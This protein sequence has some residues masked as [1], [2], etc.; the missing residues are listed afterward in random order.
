MSAGSRWPCSSTNASTARFRRRI[1][2]TRTGNPLHSWRVLLLP[3]LGKAELYGKLRLDEPW[4]SQHNRQ[5]H[6]AAV[7]V[8]QCP[9]ADLK[10][11]QT[12]YSV[13]VGEKT[14]FQGDKGRSLDDFGRNL[15][16][17]VEREQSL[18]SDGHRQGICWMDP[19]SELV[20]SVAYQG[21]NRR[22]NEVAGIGSPHPGGLDVGF[23]DG[24]VWFIAQNTALPWLQGMLDGTAEQRP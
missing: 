11:G 4:D 19:T 18:G 12:A 16:L 3:Y 6:D 15:I 23:R 22:E 13:V 20:Q 5:F 1:R 10:P 17:V 7:P 14:A 24:S 21:I 8:Y 9:S 2:S